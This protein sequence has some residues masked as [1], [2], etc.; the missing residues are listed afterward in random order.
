MHSLQQ[1]TADTADVTAVK[2]PMLNQSS[3]VTACSSTRAYH[4]THPVAILLDN[5]EK[6]ITPKHSLQ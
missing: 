5:V 6:G 3:G 2:S 1:T 4:Q